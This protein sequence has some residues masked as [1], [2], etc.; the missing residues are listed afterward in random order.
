MSPTQRFET[1]DPEAAHN[2][3]PTSS[4]NLFNEEE[5]LKTFRE[6]PSDAL[7]PEELASNGFYY[8]GRRDITRCAFC[9]LEVKPLI[10]F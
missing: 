6:W 3:G 10:F 8:S 4:L 2:R 9:G 1:V 5:R 7:T